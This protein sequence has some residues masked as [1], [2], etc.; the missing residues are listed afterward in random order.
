MEAVRSAGLD[1]QVTFN[2]VAAVAADRIA[3]DR[4]AAWPPALRYARQT[5]TPRPRRPP[6]PGTKRRRRPARRVPL[7]VP[8]ATKKL[9]RD[10]VDA[11]ACRGVAAALAAL[12]QAAAHHHCTSGASAGARRMTRTAP[13]KRSHARPLAAGVV[14]TRSRGKLGPIACRRV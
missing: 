11:G 3:T 13:R 6:A 7:P 14:A 1:N 8:R 4:I 5:W 12:V 10:D 2:R 9:N